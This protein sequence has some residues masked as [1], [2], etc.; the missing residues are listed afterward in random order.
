MTQAH[1]PYRLQGNWLETCNCEAG[2]NCNFGGFP[3]HGS[4]QA[5]I[6][7]A[8]SEGNFGS[9]DMAGVRAVVAVNWPKAIHEGNGVGVLFVDE[10][11]S[12]EQVT[13]VAT[14]LT[15][16][17][18]GM[19]WDLLATTLSSVEGPVLKPIEMN[20][21]GRNS[22][23]RIPGVLEASLTP[24]KNPVTGDDNEVHIVFPKGGLIWDV[25]DTATTKTM[26][27]DHGAVKFEHPGQSAFI[28][29][30][31]WTNQK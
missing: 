30:F 21:D 12:P 24:L 15:G 20:V 17:A 6:G 1:T 10:G 16:Q 29:A 3:D 13:G 19:P 25:G 28:S 14:I 31:D 5:I 22:S 7:I 8:V 11:T 23:F 27:I 18:G 2:C 9:V 4:C 26:R